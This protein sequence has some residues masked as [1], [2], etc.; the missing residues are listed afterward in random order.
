[1]I[2]NKQVLDY[3][4]QVLMREIRDEAIDDWERIFQGKMRDN[5]SKKNFQTV[6]TFSPEQV[7]FIVDMF[8]KIIDTAIHHLLWTL[9]QEEDINVL[10]KAEGNK[11]VNIREVSDGLSGELY[12]E[13]GW[14]SRFSKR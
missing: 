2:D 8:P 5:E 10:I 13:D 4:G 3:F 7:Q 12:T 6:N 11:V 9:E 14:I 1:M